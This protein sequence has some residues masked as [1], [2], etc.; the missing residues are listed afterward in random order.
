MNIKDKILNLDNRDYHMHSM[1]FS[2]GM[3]TVDEI[4]K[5]A[6]ELWMTEIAITDH[7]DA[8][9]KFYEKNFW[10]SK[11]IFRGFIKKWKNVHNDVNV[12]FWVEADILD[13][14]WNVN[15]LI[16]WFESNFINLSAHVNVYLW[17][18][19]NINKAYKKAIENNHEKIN[20]I[21]HTCSLPN[22]WNEVDI[23][24]LV[25]LANK[26]KIPLEI[27]WSYLREWKTHLNKLDYL[28]KNANKIYI[29][30]DAHTFFDLKEN[31]KFVINYLKEKNYI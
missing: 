26:Y 21:C 4:V 24:E 31:R 7:S 30:S 20:C 11:S 2:D 19:E 13:E 29:N 23:E 17:E 15:F 1:N 22:F 25:N 3:N 8:V 18:T 27:N 6:W 12:I 5:F 28:I 10:I 16:Q 9:M 14:D